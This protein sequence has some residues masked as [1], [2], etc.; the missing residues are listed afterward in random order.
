MINI[1]EQ[2]AQ[3]AISTVVSCSFSLFVFY[4]LRRYL[5]KKTGEEENTKKEREEQRIQRAI[6]EA[7]RR[8]AAGRL[9]FWLYKAV[10]KPPPNGELE[11]A[12][13]N[14]NRVEEKQKSLEQKIIADHDVGS[15]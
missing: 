8:R 15:G 6:V 13:N 4:Y 7:E 9:F 2:A 5:D 11:E 1:A 14:Y 12:M 10:T 3:T